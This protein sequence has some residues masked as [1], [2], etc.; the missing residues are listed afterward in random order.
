MTQS[1]ATL[2]QQAPGV[3]HAARQTHDE[4]A[5]RCADPGSHGRDDD[6]MASK[7]VVSRAFSLL[8][9]FSTERPVLSLGALADY[10]HLP[11]STTH[12]IAASLV[13]C[14]ALQRYGS[15][16]YCVGSS[17]H[18]IGLLS[19]SRSALTGVAKPF[20]HEL[21]EQTRMAVHLGVH[22]PTGGLYLD[23]VHRCGGL[24]LTTKPG[25]HFPVHS[26]ALGKSLL[27]FIE[28]AAQPVLDR[29]RLPRFTPRTLTNSDQLAKELES[30]RA[31]HLTYDREET[32]PGVS[33]IAAPVIDKFGVCIAAISVCGPSSQ[34][35]ELRSASALRRTAR[36][37]A[38][39]C[40]SRVSTLE[41]NEL[42][43]S[44]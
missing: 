41:S 34:L 14:G 12:R 11:K 24:S 10:A 30:A 43:T 15:I 3:D 1:D 42:H 25:R 38:A 13:D 22:T 16:G 44:T 6:H 17:L 31:D 28:S 5:R 40:P 39:A 20:L 19:P 23:K 33:C 7:S 35:N 9:A 2:A 36:D 8:Q 18:D 21:H 27:A 37:V 29:G 32:V 4:T 26:T